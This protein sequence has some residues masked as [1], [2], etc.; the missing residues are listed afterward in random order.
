MVPAGVVDVGVVDVEVVDVGVVGVK[1]PLFFRMSMTSS[2][3]IP[4]A[5]AT[6]SMITSAVV[7][8]PPTVCPVAF[9]IAALTAELPVST[10]VLTPP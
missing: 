1:T 9:L 7:V 4:V 10:P 8:S 3:G 2:I 5:L 6:V